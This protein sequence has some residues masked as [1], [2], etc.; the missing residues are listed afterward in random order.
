MPLLVKDRPVDLPHRFSASDGCRFCEMLI[1]GAAD[2]ATWTVVAETERFV[3]VPSI[4]AL[5]PGWLLV[6]PKRHVLNLGALAPVDIEILESDLTAIGA[7]WSETFGPLTMF[8]HGPKEPSSNVGCGVD[9]AHMHL[10]PLD[11]FD[12]L[13]AA[14][15]HLP[16]LR[17]REINSLQAVNHGKDADEPYLYLRTPD[18][19]SFLSHAPH[20]PSQALR[21]VLAI[22]QNRAEQYDWKA[23]PRLEVVRDTL[24]RVKASRI[25]DEIIADAERTAR[26][27]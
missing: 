17:W 11:A 13:A 27:A 1:E 9:H 7:W 14:K 16:A 21:R 5:V 26:A 10:V 22:E 15:Q 18:G 20:I 23:F 25:N 6:I 8:E 3:A 4:G 2:S 12:L 24:A 19:R